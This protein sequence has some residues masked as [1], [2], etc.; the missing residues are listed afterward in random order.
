MDRMMD[1]QDAKDRAELIVNAAMARRVADAARAPAT[2][3]TEPP[4]K[5]D[6]QPAGSPPKQPTK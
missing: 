3:P 4:L 5:P 2:Q 6:K 1:A